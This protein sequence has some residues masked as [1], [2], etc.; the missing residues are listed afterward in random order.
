MPK[1]KRPRT[2]F[3][4]LRELRGV[5]TKL[6]RPEEPGSLGLLPNPI[7]LIKKRTLLRSELKL[8]GRRSA[9]G[10]DAKALKEHWKRQAEEEQKKI[11]AQKKKEAELAKKAKEAAK[12][13]LKKD[14][15]FVKKAAEELSI[16]ELKE[17]LKRKKN[18]ASKRFTQKQK[19]SKK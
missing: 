5:E 6:E 3:D 13:A 4:V 15:K 9:T 12:K 16:K 1:K 8:F 19:T 11:N 14:K 10:E 17:L 18:G 7:E 2:K